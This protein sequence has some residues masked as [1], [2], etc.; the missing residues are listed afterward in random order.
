RV[1]WWSVAWAML[2]VAVFL[3]FY[4]VEHYRTFIDTVI[5]SSNH[6]YAAEFNLSFVG[7]WNRLFSETPYAIPLVDAPGLARTLV[8]LCGLATLTVC[9]AATGRR[10]GT[11]LGLFM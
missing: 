10:G 7:F 6:P 4:G 3:P 5:L 8:V 11:G 9:V 1:A 2:L